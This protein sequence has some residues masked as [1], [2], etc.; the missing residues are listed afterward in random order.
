M[1]II[2]KSGMQMMIESMLPPDIKDM[3]EKAKVE[4]PAF[5]DGLKTQVATIE[6]T[7]KRIEGNQQVIIHMLYEL[8]PAKIEETYGRNS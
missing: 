5:A 2:P 7:M 1:G 6:A 4:I 8:K 3:I